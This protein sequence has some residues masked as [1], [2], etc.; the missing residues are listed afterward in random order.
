[1]TAELSPIPMLD[2]MI[3]HLESIKEDVKYGA[4]LS[5]P[6]LLNEELDLMSTR[7]MQIA[8]EVCEQ[9]IIRD[10]EGG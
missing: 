10:V 1:M 2:E 6:T 7:L 5:S 9:L 3:S 8:E 4:N